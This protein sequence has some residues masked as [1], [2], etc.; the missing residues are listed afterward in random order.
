M[1]NGS[2]SIELGTN[3]SCKCSTTHGLGTNKQHGHAIALTGTGNVYINTTGN[4]TGKYEAVYSS[5]DTD[6]NVV[7]QNGNVSSAGGDTVIACQYDLEMNGGSAASIIA[8]NLELNGGTV[9]YSDEYPLDIRGRSICYPAEDREDRMAP[10]RQSVLAVVLSF[11][12]GLSLPYLSAELLFT[13]SGVNDGRQKC[14][15][16]HG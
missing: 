3:G 7:I 6:S 15:N 10:E 2:T 16:V 12:S 11:I 4:I 14:L 8:G 1:L 13:G 5:L 9:G